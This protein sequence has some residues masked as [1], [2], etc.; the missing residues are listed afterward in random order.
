MPD[1]EDWGVGVLGEHLTEDEDRK[2]RRVENSESVN[3]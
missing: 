2:V 1:L 3:R